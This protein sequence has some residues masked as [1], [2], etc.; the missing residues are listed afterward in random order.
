MNDRRRRWVGI[1]LAAIAGTAL[2]AGALLLV[3]PGEDEPTNDDAT[4]NLAGEEPRLQF[5]GGA[6]LIIYMEPDA[7]SNAI[8]TVN[9]VL[10]DDERVDDVTMLDK[11]DAFDEFTSIF[12]DQPDLANGLTPSDMPV[13]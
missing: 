8:A 11:A 2:V 4:A 10:A 9:T 7:S 5:R 12:S 3:F 1:A 6:D 13:S